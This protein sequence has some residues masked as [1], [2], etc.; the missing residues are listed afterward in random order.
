MSE[1]QELIQKGD[2]LVIVIGSEEEV[3]NV[4]R[5]AI[6]SQ[7]R[8]RQVGFQKTGVRSRQDDQKV[9]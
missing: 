1:L 7:A 3:G 5:R 9:L 6:Q 2:P 8:S 4:V